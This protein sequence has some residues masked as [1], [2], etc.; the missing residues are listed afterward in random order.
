[1]SLYEKRGRN[2]KGQNMFHHMGPG[3]GGSD[4]NVGG[5]FQHSLPSNMSGGPGLNNLHQRNMTQI[6]S[7]GGDGGGDSVF[8]SSI[9]STDQIQKINHQNVQMQPP[10]GSNVN[11][12]NPQLGKAIQ[13]RFSAKAPGGQKASQGHGRGDPQQ[14]LM[15]GQNIV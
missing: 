4:M 3:G 8:R 14:M 12:Q 5:G 13:Q 10:G 6:L 11:V 7:G 1:M 15:G 2:A 9:M